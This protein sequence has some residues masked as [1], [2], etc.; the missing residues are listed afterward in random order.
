MNN[1][2][3]HSGQSASGAMNIADVSDKIIL[4]Q[5][6]WTEVWRQRC[7]GAGS[8]IV[9]R[10]RGSDAEERLRHERH[11]LERLSGVEGVPKLLT[12]LDAP[13][14]IVL[15]DPDGI[16]LADVLG[17]EQFEIRYAL[18][19]ALRLTEIVIAIH[20]SGVVH[21]D[22]NP[23]NILLAGTKRQ[24]IL[25]DFDLATTALEDL[26]AFTHH[27]EI[28][29]TLTYIAPEQTG[30]TGHAVDQRADLYALGA[31]LYHLFTGHPPFPS[32]D[33]LELV[34]DHLTRTPTTPGTLAPDLP[35]GL[36]DIIL[37]LLEKVPG[38]RYQS[39]NGLAYDL[40]RVIHRQNGEEF[41]LGERDFPLR[42]MAPSRL[43]GRD[44]EIDAL[45]S[46]FEKALDSRNRG[47]LVAG[48]PG[49]GKSALVNE[50]RTIV[51]G[52]RGWFISGKF[53]QYH[54]DGTSA[55]IQALR[56]LGRILL[57]EPDD[58]L[59]KYR[60]RIHTALGANVG[61]ITVLLPEFAILLDAQAVPSYVEPVDAN[62]Q[63]QTAILDLLKA[64]VQASRPLVIVLDD[65]QWADLASIRFF[66]N[67]L[68]DETI[69]GILLVG[70]YRT[71]EVD[72]THPLAAM[73]L[74]WARLQV[75][76]LLL[77]LQ[78][79]QQADLGN[80]LAEMLRLPAAPAAAMAEA[81][82]GV[83]GG[84]PFDT[85]EL[86]NALRHEGILMLGPQGWTWDSL[87]IQRYIGPNSITDALALRIARLPKDTLQILEMLAC[88][89]EEV[90]L[91]LLQAA[92]NASAS[93][94]DEHI[95]PALE[96]GLV[97]SEMGL[98]RHGRDRKLRFRHDRVQ[99]VVHEGIDVSRLEVL[100]ITLAR[101][102]AQ[103][104]AF[105]HEAAMLYL[106]ALAQL[107]E[108]AECR[109]VIDLFSGAASS[110]RHATAYT[111]AE[112]YLNTALLLCDRL[113]T[114]VPAVL[115]LTLEQERLAALYQLGRLEEADQMYASIEARCDDAITL[116]DSAGIQISSLTS[117]SEER[118]ALALGFSLLR[119]LGL[120]VPE[121]DFG[122]TLPARLD[123]FYGWAATLDVNADLHRP[124]VQDRRVIAISKLIHQLTNP[125]VFIH[126]S[127]S[128]WLMFE[129]QRLW[130]EH[131]PAPALTYGLATVCT[132]VTG[133]RNDYRTGYTVIR[134]ILAV[135]EARGYETESAQARFALTISGAPWFEPLHA[136]IP[137][138]HRACEGLLRGGDTQVASYAYYPA[139]VAFLDCGPSLENYATEVESALTF[140]TRTGNERCYGIYLPYRQL[141][142]ALQGKTNGPGSFE[143][144]AFDETI[145]LGDIRTNPLGAFTYH[146]CRALSAALFDDQVCLAR[147][148]TAAMPL[149][150]FMEGMYTTAQARL[151]QA[152]SLA[153][154]IKKGQAADRIG[155]LSEFDACREWLAARADDA[156]SNFLH[157]LGWIDA[158]RA[159]AVGDAWGAA[160]AFESALN[161]LEPSRCSWQK[162]IILER[163]GLF[164]RT[165]GLERT[166]HYLL[167]EAHKVYDDW[168]AV[169]KVR[170]LEHM[171]GLKPIGARVVRAESRG[172]SGGISADA[173]D[174]LAILRVSQALSS[175]RT[176]ERLTS[177][178]TELIGAMTG[179][180]K[181]TLLSRDNDERHWR[182]WTEANG[183][184]MQSFSTEDAIAHQL[185][186]LSAFHYVERTHEPLL[187]A[188]AVLDDRFSRDSYLAGRHHCSL[189]L[190]P[191]LSKGRANAI[192]VLENH[193]NDAAF[194]A[195]R[196]DA[197]EL[198]AGQLAVSLEN[199]QLYSSLERKVAERTEELKEVNS[200][201]AAMVITDPLTGLSN[202]RHFAQ[203]LE[204]EWQRALRART[205]LGA[206]MVDIDQFKQYNDHY[207]HQ[208]GDACLRIVAATLGTHFRVGTDLVARYG[209][210][211]F[212][213]VMPGA[214]YTATYLA[215]DRARIA[216]A[217]LREPHAGADRGF[218]TISMGVASTIPSQP[219]GAE[220]L[221]SAADGA[222]YEAKKQ[223]RNRVK[224]KRT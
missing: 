120:S 209:G 81:V 121:D 55:T 140:A 210:E 183:R 70:T 166:G 42:L 97:V 186:P 57:S 65:L 167:A 168:G 217:K 201:L 25:I 83:T 79:L 78:N 68:C 178:V 92:A 219:T 116:A 61:L 22:I 30:R 69:R 71:T 133:M 37:R 154:R 53:D 181:V 224:G 34:R 21:R 18:E 190:V 127:V 27:N 151:L 99:Q 52:Q 24:P 31:T 98:L 139:I 125:A 100:R 147:H 200:R 213:I 220:Q 32:D 163:A 173:L 170:E 43:C 137:D 113:G 17:A 150:P 35:I 36:S 95:A 165:D 138:A 62:A 156:P 158:E 76:P 160:R 105:A 206:V 23:A 1:N 134:H 130:V 82:C 29:G 7:P 48:G 222:L 74:G 124:E 103:H 67:I 207:G 214:D 141:L 58:E 88:I 4:Y 12:L 175:E 3:G 49:V 91:D 63:L 218:V 128:A 2:A 59:A 80:M 108:S 90:S 117:R 96:D 104:S 182:L 180:T 84:N 215:A 102:L 144:G 33:P 143:D 193:L 176:L 115:R 188:N 112:R 177:R 211:E 204:A 85:V 56:G 126:R 192:L 123:Q 205:S 203:V 202:R 87:A 44:S 164:H 212:A 216:V 122:A 195:S 9:K 135:A 26:P 198:I 152:L 54:A 66:D 15:D 109:H 197:V 10:P 50:L 16:P 185:L 94:L 114:S 148:V 38:R 6:E 45:K 41:P 19:L 111:L 73:Q 107:S 86:V 172:R 119:S 169:A 75:T 77:S 142:R 161:A 199:V 145:H 40:S 131:G 14:A 20:R 189:L 187:V 171:H 184:D 146:V 28:V 93:A 157:L 60:S 39:A 101:R 13:D 208:G 11:I 149:L 110:A 129:S 196:L 72:A 106:D 155:L 118:K 8:V 132:V 174:L 5:S 221:F 136:S 194:S 159:W 51:T 47:V 89:G 191:I 223:G 64:I 46:A 162:A 179:A 153:Q